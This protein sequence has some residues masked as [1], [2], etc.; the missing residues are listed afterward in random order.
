M[1]FFDKLKTFLLKDKTIT[2]KG[3]FLDSSYFLINAN[4]EFNATYM[5]CAEVLARH[6]S[7][8]KIE[9]R[10]EENPFEGRNFVYLKHLLQYKPNEI[11]DAANF[12]HSL[13]YDYYFSG[14]CFAYL[15]WNYNSN[16]IR[17]RAIYPIDSKDLK[18]VYGDDGEIYFN[19]I[20]N[21]R[22]IYCS[23]ND[24]IFVSRHAKPD[25]PLNASS[26]ALNKVLEVL[27]TNDEGMIKAIQNANSIRFIISQ[28]GNV[29]KDLM[30]KNQ[31][32]LEEQIAK[33]KTVLYASNATSIQPINPTTKWIED[34]SI[35][36]LKNEIYSFFNVTSDFVKGKYNE[37]ER[38]SIYE[39]A[40]EPFIVALAQELT[41][42]LFTR[43]EFDL[44][45]RI[46]VRTDPLQTASLGTRIKIAEAYL[47]LPIIVPNVVSDLLYLPRSEHGDKEVQSLNFVNSSKVDSYQGVGSKED[48]EN[49]EEN[50][51]EDSN[52]EQSDE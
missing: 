4:R 43:R 15:D 1:G 19:F 50:S 27:A 22:N 26:S 24:I 7:K 23:V 21:S 25:S 41:V 10:N 38:Q 48:S 29:N 34:E 49:E 36:E 13:A 46:Y 33:A 11:Q 51:E 14:C 8:L 30:I 47:K 35:K 31:E 45:N 42:K 40:I 17:L 32:A 52:N 2:K 16:P 39:G 18:A 37:N 5:N 12:L 3:K 44:G 28:A 20:I 6:I 9:V